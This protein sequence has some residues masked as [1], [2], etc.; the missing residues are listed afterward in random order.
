MKPC[1]GT[2][3]N[4]IKYSNGKWNSHCSECDSITRTED[5]QLEMNFEFAND[6]KPNLGL[7]ECDCGA[8]KTPNP[9]HHSNWCSTNKKD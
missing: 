1:C 9:E 5:S 2:A 6:Y 4:V 3:P 8:K 7:K